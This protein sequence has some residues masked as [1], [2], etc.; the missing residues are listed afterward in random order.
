MH[1]VMKAMILAAGR[2]ERMRSLTDAMP[3]PL[4]KAGSKPLILYHIEALR[5][6]GIIDLV[7]NHAYRGEMIV[8]FLG[9]GA[10]FGVN[11][12]YSEEASALETG[13]GIF[14][15]LRYLGGSPFV[16]VNGDIWTD[17]DFSQ[18]KESSVKKTHLVMVNNPAHHPGGDFVLQPDT[19]LLYCTES[20]ERLTYSG[21]ALID[22]ALFDS[23]QAVRFPLG[24]LLKSAMAQQWVTGELYN[25]VWMDI[26]TPQRLVELNRWL[27][28]S[29]HS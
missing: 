24:P 23:C 17:Y 14:K 1:P 18:L 16:I 15:A 28:M 10:D 8:N 5:R 25:G 26:G 27:E 21:I 22:P 3:K 7:I 19:G 2:G 20:Q 4:L 11:I 9:D 29:A 12:V 6:A 13:G